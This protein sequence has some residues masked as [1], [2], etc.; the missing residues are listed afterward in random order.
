MIAVGTESGSLHVA[1]DVFEKHKLHHIPKLH[2]RMIRTINF[3]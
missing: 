1:E 3:T 2:K